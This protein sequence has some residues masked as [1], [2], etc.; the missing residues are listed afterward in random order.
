MGQ[1]SVYPTTREAY[2]LFHRGSLALAECEFNGIRTDRNYCERTSKGLD[3]QVV[4]LK[5]KIED[6]ELG[7]VWIGRFKNP[8]WTS[9]D[10]LRKVLHDT[11]GIE[12]E[13]WTTG[14]KRKVQLPSVT[15]AVLQGYGVDGIAELL[16]IRQLD[17][18]STDLKGLLRES[19]P[20]G[21]IHPFFHLSD[22]GNKEGGARS[23]RGS[24]SDPNFQNKANR[25]PFERKTIRRALIPREGFR[26]VGRD[27]GGIEVCVSACNHQDPN[28]IRYIERGD[29]MHRD[30][31]SMCFKLPPEQCT[32]AFGEWGK[33]ARF[34][35]KNSFTF[36][37]FY[38]QEPENTTKGLWRSIADLDL[39]YPADPEKK[40]LQHLADRR[41][42]TYE[43]FEA[44]IKK[45]CERFWREMFPGYG[46]W[47]D[48]WI[49]DYQ[50]KGYF[51]MLTGF[52]VEGV[53][54]KYQLGNYPI[55]GPAFHTLLWSL[56]K[57]VDLWQ[58]KRSG[59]F[60]SLVVGQIHD[61]LVTDEEEREFFTNVDEVQKIM[62][63]DVRKEWSW[64]IV[65]LT[66]ETS[67]TPVDG[68]WFE[69]KGI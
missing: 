40:M 54:S 3:R 51:D 61:E 38:F 53:M 18:L 69:K 11:M 19:E 37:Q 41:I 32:K 31:A 21:C 29:D 34:A 30:V 26:M 39:R 10:Q 6:T 46:K 1:V 4:S 57:T 16:K 14:G 12:P 43:A 9:D 25:H 7:K 2:D 49:A 68:T 24:S 44:H 52:R 28:M 56:T 15:A 62:S 63:E 50:K 65:P 17:K 13:G 66:V 23:F 45:V 55:Q 48:K 67:A 27:Y 8:N 5:T 36:A 42:R 47:R 33:Q 64:I 20:D 58:K 59:G 35:G 22:Y 60:K